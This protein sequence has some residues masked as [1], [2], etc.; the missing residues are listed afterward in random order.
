M[1]LLVLS[2]WLTFH[3]PRLSLLFGPKK[4]PA[5]HNRNEK[6][7]V[8]NHS[9]HPTSSPSEDDQ[10]RD[11][12]CERTRT[13]MLAEQRRELD[14]LEAEAKRREPED[15]RNE[16]FIRFLSDDT[17]LFQENQKTRE[18][19]FVEEEMKQEG[20]FKEK[21]GARN[22][23]FEEAQVKREELV[24]YAQE[25]R[26][27]RA[28]WYSVHREEVGNKGRAKRDKLFETLVRD[29]QWQFDEFLKAEVKSFVQLQEHVN[30]NPEIKVRSM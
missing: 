11:A 23:A 16:E 27:K 8:I 15:A 12:E 19:A 29:L 13:F 26:L 4:L 7:E 20:I 24:K 30:E 18:A 6:R 2:D 22:S 10:Y 21:E 9:P 3:P 25:R 17:K 1:L 5:Q 14:F 28:K